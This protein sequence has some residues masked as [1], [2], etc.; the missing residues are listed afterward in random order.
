MPHTPTTYPGCT[1]AGPVLRQTHTHTRTTKH[2]AREQFATYANHLPRV[3]CGG[4]GVVKFPVVWSQVMTTLLPV[5]PPLHDS[6]HD[7]P[8]AT[9]APTVQLVAMYVLSGDAGTMHAVV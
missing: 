8:P 3:H 6:A 2:G 1:V 7:V 9:V 5:E 4:A